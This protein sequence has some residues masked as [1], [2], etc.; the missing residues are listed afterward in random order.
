MLHR[1]RC[2]VHSIILFIAFLFLQ[3]FVMMPK[4]RDSSQPKIFQSPAA[5]A[6]AAS[7]TAA[8]A[9]S[10]IENLDFKTAELNSK[11]SGNHHYE[12]DFTV[13]IE[14][15]TEKKS[16]LELSLAEVRTENYRIRQNIEE[17]NN[18]HAE[19]SKVCSLETLV[20]KV[21]IVF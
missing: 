3:V 11:G 21:I 12:Q 7:V 8:Y 10:K 1:M 15:L 16:V 17:V 14:A 9:L 13:E 6:A 4:P 5:A 18:T 19:L 2:V 20:T